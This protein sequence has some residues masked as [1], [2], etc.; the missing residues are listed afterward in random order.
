V[1]FC[2]SGSGDE[3]QSALDMRLAEAIAVIRAPS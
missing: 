2:C 3:N 1:V